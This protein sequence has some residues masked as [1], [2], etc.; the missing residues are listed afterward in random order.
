MDE[1]EQQNDRGFHQEVWEELRLIWT[2]LLG[3][4]I[5]TLFGFFVA[6]ALRMNER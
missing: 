1:A 6:A 4:A 2:F 3:L 5:G